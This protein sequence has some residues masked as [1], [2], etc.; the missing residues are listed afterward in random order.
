MLAHSL[1][2]LEHTVI[3][4][5]LSLR[6]RYLKAQTFGFCFLDCVKQELFNNKKHC[7]R[8]A[9]NLICSIVP[10]VHAVWNSEILL[11]LTPQVRHEP[12]KF[13]KLSTD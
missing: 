7:E 2:S 9:D 3:V 5:K 8:D 12:L 4:R 10:K 11:S 1:G 13:F 6:I